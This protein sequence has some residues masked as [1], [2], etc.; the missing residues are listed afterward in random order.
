MPFGQ[1]TSGAE[2]AEP[3]AHHRAPDG[4]GGRAAR[5]SIG[6]KRMA[7]TSTLPSSMVTRSLKPVTPRGARTTILL[8]SERSRPRDQHSTA[9]VRHEPADPAPTLQH[10]LDARGG[11]AVDAAAD[12]VGEQNP[13]APIRPRRLDQAVPRSES[14]ELETPRAKPVTPR[15][16]PGTRA[17]PGS[18]TNQNQL[19]FP[20]AYSRSRPSSSAPPH[21]PEPRDGVRDG[22]IP[23]LVAAEQLPLVGAGAC[24]IFGGSRFAPAS[25]R[26]ES[27]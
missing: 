21:I 17:L 27:S 18:Q 1:R 5:P 13:A 3:A 6:L 16:S 8:S 25:A 12:H 23:R 11:P 9:L 10:E 22:S 26:L 4:A 14:L 19:P 2:H 15:R 20:A 24:A 7:P